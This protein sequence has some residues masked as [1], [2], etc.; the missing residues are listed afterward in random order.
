MWSTIL[1]LLAPFG[2]DVIFRAISFDVVI[3][4]LSQIVRVILFLLLRL[5]LYCI[6]LFILIIIGIEYPRLGL[7]PYFHCFVALYSLL[8]GYVLNR[9]LTSLLE[10]RKYGVIQGANS[11][12]EL[13]EGIRNSEIVLECLRKIGMKSEY[14]IQIIADAKVLYRCYAEHLTDI[15]ARD[16]NNATREL[17][18]DNIQ[19]LEQAALKS[20]VKANIGRITLRN[21]LFISDIDAKL[22]IEGKNKFVLSKLIIDE[23]KNKQA[24]LKYISYPELVD[25]TRQHYISE[26]TFQLIFLEDE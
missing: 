16:K 4:K 2:I 1:S 17:N 5:F 25:L 3:N 22:I 8:A 20:L 9:L 26:S 13:T 19:Y 21:L 24:K 18:L 11:M 15:L 7:S 6:N 10:S 14:N 12:T 23:I